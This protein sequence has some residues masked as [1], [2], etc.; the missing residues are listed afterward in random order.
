MRNKKG[1]YC[2]DAPTEMEI[3][4]FNKYSPKNQDYFPQNNLI[5][6]FNKP[7]SVKSIVIVLMVIWFFNSFS[8][9]IKEEIYSK[10]ESRFCHLHKNSSININD[11]DSLNVTKKKEK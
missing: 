11:I 2:S 8:L 1:Q 6:S 4:K 9:T 5:E 3:E 7:P 10:I